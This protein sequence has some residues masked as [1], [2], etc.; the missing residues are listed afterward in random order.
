[1]ASDKSSRLSIK[2]I[3]HGGAICYYIGMAMANQPT[4]PPGATAEGVGQGRCARVLFNSADWPIKI[5]LLS[6]TI[7]LVFITLPTLL[8]STRC[9]NTLPPQVPLRLRLPYI[10]SSITA[11]CFW[12]VVE[13]V[14]SSIGGCLTAYQLMTLMSINELT[15]IVHAWYL[16]QF[17]SVGSV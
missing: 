2:C 10:P 7:I 4:P 3:H 11:A 6:T 13:S 16:R 5:S 17:L 8:S 1:L 14:L 12:L 9:I 15:S